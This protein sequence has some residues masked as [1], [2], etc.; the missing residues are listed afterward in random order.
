[1]A[2]NS[3]TATA[4]TAATENCEES[5]HKRLQEALI[6]DPEYQG[7]EL[8][9]LSELAKELGNVNIG[10]VGAIKIKYPNIKGQLTNF[11]RYRLLGNFSGYKYHQPHGTPV[12]VYLPRSEYW[13][14]NLADLNRPLV[15]TEGEFKAIRASHGAIVE[16]HEL[17]VGFDTIGLGGVCSI[18]EKYLG[19]RRLL[20]PLNSIPTGKKVYICFDYDGAL[21]AVNPGDPKAEVLKAEQTLASMLK[22]RG[23]TVFFIRLGESKSMEKV[24]LDDFINAKG[25]EGFDLKL[26]QAREFKPNK[27][28]GEVFLHSNYAVMAGDVVC[29][30]TGVILPYTKFNALEANCKNPYEP[31]A[32]DKVTPCQKFMK[33][34]NRTTIE[35]ITFDPRITGLITP[36]H[37]LNLWRGFKTKPVKGDVSLWLEFVNKF[38]SMDQE[39]KHDFE[40]CMAL[41]LQKP[42]VKQER[43]CILLSAMTG[44]G[45][46]F[47][48]ETIAAVIN[49]SKK[50]MPHGR[51]N[52]ALVTSARDLDG[53]FNALLADKKLVVFNEIGEKGE[54]HTNLLKDMVTGN[55][56]TINAKYAQPRT[57]PNYLQICITSNESF[58]H[59]VEAHS[60]RELIYM[61]PKASDLA[62]EMREFFAVNTALKEWVNTPEARS[63]LLDYYL[64]Y[65]LTG[66]DGTQP[67]PLN[68]SKEAVVEATLRDIDYYIMEELDDLDFI[69]P[70]LEYE[71]FLAKNPK[72]YIRQAGAAVA[73]KTYGFMKGPW[74]ENGQM[75]FGTLADKTPKLARPYIWYKKRSTLVSGRT[76]DK[77]AIYEIILERYY[78]PRKI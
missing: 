27:E 30:A 8:V 49:N 15:I 52:H 22:L 39:V 58:T 13:V 4:Q 33:A 36:H 42:W 66:Y 69:I 5:Y 46:S 77:E 44:V 68:E 32:E 40:A 10:V 54:K 73:F 17:D 70:G 59:L 57:I 14:R 34:A 78:N 6:I 43:I 55:S 2:T 19:G 56:I 12:T 38:F 67:A 1:M 20:E 74:N 64:N 11:Y 76:Y 26:K 45:K 16:G 37:E 72:S 47:Y 61:I 35:N 41:T 31:G 48:F 75:F 62:I 23:C 53:D 7:I 21:D 29:I 60:R 18:T 51:F 28:D 63:A 50:G 3:F 71:K 25:F 9:P 24:G 65:D